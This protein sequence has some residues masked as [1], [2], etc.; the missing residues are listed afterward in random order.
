[1][2]VVA[3]NPAPNDQQRF[4]R[5]LG[6]AAQISQAQLPGDRVAA[7]GASFPVAMAVLAVVIALALAANELFSARLT[8]E[9]RH[10]KDGAHR[11]RARR[12]GACGRRAAARG[13]RRPL[14][15]ADRGGRSHDGGASGRRDPLDPVDAPSVRSGAAARR[16]GRRHRAA[17][18]DPRLR[19]RPAHRHGG[20]TTARSS[21][22]GARSPNRRSRVSS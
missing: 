11:P 21:P 10:V 16:S 3:L 7:T 13:R 20:S 5:L 9:T 22:F 18:G 2:K 12:A 19:D 6:K 15:H 14:A 1:M 8:L 17:R 4:Q